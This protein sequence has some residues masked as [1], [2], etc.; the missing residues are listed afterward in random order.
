MST[1]EIITRT[2]IIRRDDLGIIRGTYTTP[3][4][5][6]D[7]ARENVNALRKLSAGRR[8][9]VLIDSRQVTALPPEARTHYTSDQAADTIRALAILVG[10]SASRLVG[11]VFI[12]FQNSR[13]RTKLF[14]DEAA[15]IAWLKSFLL[16]SDA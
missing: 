13:I 7:D 6:L 5:T 3:E 1:A 2:S 14:T 12:G 4:E 11:N 9:L 15:A 10:S 16:R 8:A